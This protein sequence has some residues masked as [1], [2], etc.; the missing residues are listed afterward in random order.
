M[1]FRIT[2]IPPYNTD[3]YNK[4]LNKVRFIDGFQKYIN[5]KK[6]DN[7]LP[8]YCIILIHHAYLTIMDSVFPFRVS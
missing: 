6:N 1:T 8:A 7:N 4:F 2:H 3:C 5:H